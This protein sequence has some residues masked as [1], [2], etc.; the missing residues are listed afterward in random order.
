MFLWCQAA[1]P[2]VLGRPGVEMATRFERR[3]IDLGRQRQRGDEA[4]ARDCRQPLAD[5]IGFVRGGQFDF[6]FFDPGVEIRDRW[7]NKTAMFLASDG[8][9]ASCSMAASNRPILLSLCRR[10]RQIRRRVRGAC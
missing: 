8:M 6:N 3:R 5:R 2:R 9:A 10:S 4:Y 7:P 1:L